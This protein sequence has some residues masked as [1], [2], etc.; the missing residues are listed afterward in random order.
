VKRAALAV[1]VAVAVV[2]GVSGCGG[3]STAAS[4]PTPQPV[5]TPTCPSVAP[6]ASPT[7]AKAEKAL[8]SLPSDL[9]TPSNIT[10][11][12]STVTTD[13]VHVVRF[14]TPTSLRQAV[15]FI[16]GSYPKAG[17]V[18]GRGDA[19]ATEA[20]APF[21]HGQV[22]GLTRVAAVQACQTLWLVAST[23][24]TVGSGGTQ[25]MLSPHPTSA[26]TSALPFG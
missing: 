10:V 13:G 11:V 25:P 9:P 26:T 7:S 22:R 14:T 20:D 1:S 18:L 2:L 15:I 19:E 21:V 17:Y 6:S 8:R 5:A 3:S 23:T 16:V 24:A 12:D 4:A